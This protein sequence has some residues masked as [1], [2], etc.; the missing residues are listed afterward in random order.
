MHNFRKPC[1]K[2]GSSTKKGGFLYGTGRVKACILAFY[3]CGKDNLRLEKE[4]IQANVLAG[5]R[6]GIFHR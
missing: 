5:R 2:D 3:E 1:Q 4:S 6:R